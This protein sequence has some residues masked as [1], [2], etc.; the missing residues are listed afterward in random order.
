MASNVEK[1]RG[2]FS[3][4]SNE[5]S[6]RMQ[7][8]VKK[9]QEAKK[10]GFSVLNKEECKQGVRREEKILEAIED[11]PQLTIIKANKFLCEKIVSNPERLAA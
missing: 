8:I 6:E 11:S 3:P 1:F 9:L 4:E 2:L 7:L 5:L 10:C